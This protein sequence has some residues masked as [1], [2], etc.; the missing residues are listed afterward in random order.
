MVDDES[1]D[2]TYAIAKEFAERDSRI[3]LLQKEYQSNLAATR[4]FLF[5]HCHG[6]YCVWV[7]SDDYV[8]PLYIE[9][10]YRT[11]VDN[12]AD[13]SACRFGLQVTRLPKIF[14]PRKTVDIFT[15]D[16]IMAQ[17]I[18]KVAV[19]MWNKMYRVDLIKQ[20]PALTFETTYAPNQSVNMNGFGEDIIFN[21]KYIERC[22]KVAFLKRKLYHYSWR[23]GSEM[24][25]KYGVKQINLINRLIELC[26]MQDN[27]ITRDALRA[28]TAFSCCGAV[29]FANQRQFP[30]D[31]ARMRKF[32]YVYRNEL[33]KNRLA[34]PVFK[35]ILWLGL[36]TWCRPEKTRKPKQERN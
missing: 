31:I 1:T 20:E 34:K 16:E 22:Q 10:L 2:N 13:M 11:L 30:E 35:T 7:D 6:K 19:V 23:A 15:G 9:K 36:K 27:P 29:Y 24:H 33:Y 25:K 28:W 3:V 18:F 26:D 32:A 21:L 17:I 4:N 14:V 5:E 12:H 8:H